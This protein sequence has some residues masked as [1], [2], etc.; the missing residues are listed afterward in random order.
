MK[1]SK[2]LVS[3]FTVLTLVIVMVACS[4]EVSASETYVTVDINPSIELVVNRQDEVVYVNALNE[5][6]EILLLELELIGL[7]VEDAMDLIINKAIELGYID[8]D[9]EEVVVSVSTPS[10]TKLGLEVREQ[11]KDAI[12]KAFSNK[13]MMGKAIDKAFSDEFIE[14]A[15]SYDVTPAFLFLAYHVT[16]VDD[17]VSL[18]D[19]LLMSR[20]ELIDILK[21]TKAEA[22]Q[23]VA[24]YKEEFLQAREEI[25]ARYQ[26][27]IDSLT[28]QIADIETQIAALEEPSSELDAQLVALEAELATLMETC[29][30]EVNALRTNYIDMGKEIVNEYREKVEQRRSMFSQSVQQWIE[31]R[32]N[33]REQIKNDIENYQNN[34]SK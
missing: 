5:D 9:A 14:E 8:I 29:Q 30:G 25:K 23:I 12:N 11:V 21:E 24:T 32:E 16:Y 7:D 20:A 26:D 22:K 10:E 17:T 34:K 33:R 19:A 6:A 15:E 2:F 28:S 1:K 13:A 18:E 3:L 4:G 31:N 27:Q